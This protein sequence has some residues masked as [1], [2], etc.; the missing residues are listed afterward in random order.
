MLSY[1]G[2]LAMT[3]KNDLQRIIIENDLKLM[4]NSI[5]EKIIVQKDIVN[6]IEDIR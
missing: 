1:P 3:I 5:L 6:L 4:I 2:S